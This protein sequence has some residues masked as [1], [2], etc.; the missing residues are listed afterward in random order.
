MPTVRQNMNLFRGQQQTHAS[1]TV[2]KVMKVKA[3][4]R[5]SPRQGSTEVRRIV[6]AKAKCKFCGR[7]HAFDRKQCPAFG[8]KSHTCGR[9]N[10]FAK[11]CRMQGKRIKA[12]VELVEG[13]KPVYAKPYRVPNALRP[14]VELELGKLEKAGVI[15]PVTSSDWATGVV[16][17]PKKNGAIRLCGNY[18]TTV[19]PQ[20]KTVSA[21]NI[22]IDV[23]LADL[24]G[25]VKFS[26][27]DLANAY[28]QME[29]F[30]ESREYLTIAT[31]NGLFRQNRLF[32]GIT[33]A[34]AIW[35]NAIEKV[36]QGLPG[37]KLIEW[38]T[39][40]PVPLHVRRIQ[41]TERHNR[42]ASD[43]VFTNGRGRADAFDGMEAMTV[44]CLGALRRG[45]L[46]TPVG[47]CLPNAMSGAR[48]AATSTDVPQLPPCDF[49][50]QP[51]KGLPYE[52][53]GQVRR[54]NLSPG[55]LT[56]YKRPVLIHQGHMQWLFDH[57]GRRYLDMFAG[58][59]TV[60]VG[61]CHP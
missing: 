10:H 59:V 53:V 47:R 4:K 7:E 22:N 56:F 46:L 41:L 16:V 6:P 9:E 52:R 12:H 32:F 40:L 18:K 21:P 29:V 37:V 42:R 34:P 49:K 61:H 54:E 5:V 55:T 17:V 14:K 35:Q 50:P 31:H 13:A 25:G 1:A 15:T 48:T 44:K 30:E 27:L 60:S 11:M 51:Y 57:E 43:S 45:R 39:T 36:L 24:A 33:T 26:K 58:I 28:N 23:I 3:D 38:G 2:N 20:L 8:K 19:N